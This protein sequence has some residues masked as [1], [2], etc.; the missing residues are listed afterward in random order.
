[1]LSDDLVDEWVRRLRAEVPDAVAIFLTGSQL[2]GDAGPFSDVDFD[3]LVAKGPRD[4][5][6]AFVVPY[7]GR[8]VRVSG[9]VRDV[10]S[11][12]ASSDESQAWAFHLPCA[13]PLRLC[14]AAD[15]WRARVERTELTHPAGPPEADHFE[16]DVGKVA[17]AWIDGDE[18]LLRLSAADLARSVVSLLAPLNP[19]P[20]VR[21]RG[22]ALRS[23]LAFDKVPAGYRVD[24]LTCL[25]LD[26]EPATEE[27]AK[28][29]RRLAVGTAALVPESLDAAWVGQAAD[30]LPDGS[31]ELW[32]VWRQ[33]DNGNRFE[34]SRKGSRSE[35]ES[36]AATM[37]ARGHKQIYWVA[38]Q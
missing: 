30:R 26:G 28:A 33:D 2:R 18:H 29:A 4:D 8:S 12:S 19:R 3:V 23:L 22:E 20:P 13:D 32:I 7:G 38:R 27:V 14:W 9:R 31:Q 36:L 15:P 34:V 1:M 10:E 17:N 24:M 6:A 25:G 11:W 16:G 5:G 21:S 35:A 37:E